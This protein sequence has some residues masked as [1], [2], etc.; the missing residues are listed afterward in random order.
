MPMCMHPWLPSLH[1]SGSAFMISAITQ[2][3]DA[4]GHITRSLAALALLAAHHL[5]G[6]A[7][8]LALVRLRRALGAHVGGKLAHQLLE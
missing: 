2:M 8:A 5:I 7:H 1:H 6:V 3:G 4:Q